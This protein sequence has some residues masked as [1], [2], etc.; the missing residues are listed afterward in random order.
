M[1][2]GKKIVK[3]APRK[4]RG[5]TSNR[6]GDAAWKVAEREVARYFGT[7]RAPIGQKGHDTREVPA[8]TDWLKAKAP[9]LEIRAMVQNGPTLDAFSHVF[10]ESKCHLQLLPT[11]ERWHNIVQANPDKKSLIPMMAL[12]DIGNGATLKSGLVGFCLLEDFPKIYR[13]FLATPVKLSNHISAELWFAN[14]LNRLWIVRQPTG[15]HGTIMKALEQ[16]EAN[17]E[18]WRAKRAAVEDT[19]VR[20]LPVVYIKYPKR[21]KPALVFRLPT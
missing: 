1:P 12:G 6:S 13:A 15:V 3:K 10:V 4:S 5:A 7:E 21:V 16:A 2:K 18:A 14:I 19:N 8:I 17:A 20:P 9:E 11:L